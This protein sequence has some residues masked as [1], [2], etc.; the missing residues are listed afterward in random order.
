MKV[1]VSASIEEES[2][3]V[4]DKSMK[5]GKYRNKSHALETA[6][7]VL[8]KEEERLEKEKKK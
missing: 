4:L 1:R 2:S 6:I 8:E 5:T 7:I 3:K